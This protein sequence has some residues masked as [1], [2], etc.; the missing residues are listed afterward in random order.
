ME[1][2]R[3]DDIPSNNTNKQARYYGYLYKINGIFYNTKKKLWFVSP[4][5]NPFLF[6]YSTENDMIPLGKFPLGNAKIS[7]CSKNSKAFE[8]H[9]DKNTLTLEAETI[10]EKNDWVN[11]LVNMKSLD[12]KSLFENELSKTPPSK[13]YKGSLDT[14]MS[15]N[16]DKQLEEEGL[17]EGIEVE[18]NCMTEAAKTFAEFQCTDVGELE[19][20]LKNYMEVVTNMGE[21]ILT[22]ESELDESHRREDELRKRNFNL[23][24]SYYR[25]KSRYLLLLNHLSYPGEYD[26]VKNQFYEIMYEEANSDLNESLFV[27]NKHDDEENK[28]CDSLGF[29]ISNTN[30]TKDSMDIAKSMAQKADAIETKLKTEKS[31]SY[32]EWITKWDDFMLKTPE[33]TPKYD[34][35][36]K[37]LVR[38]SIPGTYRAKLWLYMVNKNVDHIK[39]EVGDDNYTDPILRLIDS[40]LART[41]PGNKYFSSIRAKKIPELRR[42][43]YAYRYYNKEIGYC[44]GLNRLA[45]LGLL[46]LKEE[47]AFWFLVACINLQPKEYYGEKLTGIIIDKAVFAEIVN[48]KLPRLSSHLKSLDVDIHLYSLKWFMTIFIDSLSHEVY[49]KIFDCFLN[50]GN[51]VIF[52]FSI[53]LLKMCENDLLD[54]KTFSAANNILECIKNKNIQFSDLANYAFSSVQSFSSK[55]IN[56]KREAHYRRQESTSK[57]TK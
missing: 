3:N 14:C 30:E 15:K 41:L 34:E 11:H 50:E 40:D 54:S 4:V 23:E 38:T 48:E 56:N 13:F 12:V 8:I 17:Y 16:E 46:F 9:S 35:E 32:K 57:I 55:W 29:Y 51:K 19:V 37:K 24:A 27:D 39:V 33:N 44:Q 47:D 53:A 36:F 18:D 52:R 49:L 7:N 42:I 2:P 43:L 5:D 45:A 28:A 31:K 6:W 22:L 10:E 25:L 1:I 26:D 20:K 21:Q